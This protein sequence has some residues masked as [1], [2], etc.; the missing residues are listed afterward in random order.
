MVPTSFTK[1]IGQDHIDIKVS[2]QVV[3]GM[4]KLEL[5]LALDNTGSM[6]SS[7]KMTELKKAAKELLQTLK[8]VAMNDDDIKIAIVPFAQ[9]VNVGTTN[10]NATWLN[11]D[12]WNEENGNDVSTTTCTAARAAGAVAR[13]RDLGAGRPQD[14]ERLRDGPRPEL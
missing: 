2:S 13:P 6:A 3:W 7:N 5:A 10:V 11:W 14:L 12:E 9:E 4:K 8:K 1:V